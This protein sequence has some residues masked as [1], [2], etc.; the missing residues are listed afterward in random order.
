MTT[1]HR[2]LSLFGVL[3]LPFA[4]T[5]ADTPPIEPPAEAPPVTRALET[6]EVVARVTGPSLWELRRGEHVVW[7]L[8]VQS[9]L[10]RRFEWESPELDA[11]LA[12]S[13]L[14][15]A[16]VGFDLKGVNRVNAVFL[17]PSLIRARRDPE[18]LSLPE[19]VGPD[20][21]ARWEPLR[22]RYLAG[23]RGTDDW[24]PL[25]AALE[26]YGAAMED[27]GLSYR[28]QVWS[29]V[30]RKARRQRMQILRP[31]LEIEAGKP[32]QLIRGFA[33]ETLADLDCF[34]RTLDRLD[35]DLEAMEERAE[36]WAVG[37]VAALRGLPFRDQAQACRDAFLQAD[38]AE[39]RGLDT[40]PRRLR[41]MWLGAIEHAMARHQ[42]SVAVLDI[43]LL[44]DPE[45][46]MVESLRSLGIEVTEPD[47]KAVEASSLDAAD[48][49]E[50]TVE[51][52]PAGA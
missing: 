31:E 25:I 17:L 38:F 11:R 50:P 5:A 49:S 28:R 2:L 20:L 19:R 32:R 27:A 9:P 35:A 13:S 14:L 48:E 34:E 41:A 26:L 7:V 24:R 12:E 46:A 18:G 39:E 6:V 10:P 40:L 47:A 45:L 21:Y 1:A 36:A 4:V 23:K 33:G 44:L 3:L 15:I 37:D 29:S 51:R 16:P 42:S 52:G 22:D 43:A 8:A 30:E